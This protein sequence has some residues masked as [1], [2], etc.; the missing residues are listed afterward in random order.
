MQF[1]IIYSISHFR[2][3]YLS[4]LLQFLSRLLAN[5]WR[6]YPKGIGNPI[7]TSGYEYLLF[8]CRCHSRNVAWFSYWFGNLGLIT[9]GNTYRS[10]A[11]SSLP[12]WGH[13]D[14]VQAAS[15]G[16][17]GAVAEETSPTST[18]F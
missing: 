2:E 17:F 12:L 3:I 9:E 4:N 16:V 18:R 1:I 14:V 10:C 8:V 5:F 7:N 6:R 15:K 13:T 11:T